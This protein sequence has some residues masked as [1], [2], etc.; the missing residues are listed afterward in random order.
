MVL[1]G[2]RG[3]KFTVS[4]KVYYIW[5]KT[6]INKNWGVLLIEKNNFYGN[7]INEN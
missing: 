3:G 5:L 6:E 2:I 4:P 7:D 1:S